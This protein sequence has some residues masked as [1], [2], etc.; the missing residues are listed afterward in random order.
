[1]RRV[2]PETL[3]D[4]CILTEGHFDAI[5]ALSRFFYDHSTAKF[6]MLPLFLKEK[7]QI[8]NFRSTVVVK[9]SRERFDGLK[10][11]HSQ[12]ANVL[13]SSRANAAHYT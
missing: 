4:V 9:K 12:Y 6:M 5:E 8:I 2:C 7:R 3:Q 1:M 10:M 13:Q 11:T